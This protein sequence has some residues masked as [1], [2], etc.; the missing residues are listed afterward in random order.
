MAAVVGISNKPTGQ[1]A[2]FAIDQVLRER[3]E[4]VFSGRG[5]RIGVKVRIE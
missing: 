1:G 4:V 2:A 3:V 5:M